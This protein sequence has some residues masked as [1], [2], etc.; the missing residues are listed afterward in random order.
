MTRYREAPVELFSPVES[1][2]TVAVPSLLPCISLSPSTRSHPPHRHSFPVP[3]ASRPGWMGNS[4]RYI[5]LAREKPIRRHHRLPSPMRNPSARNQSFA[6]SYAY[7]TGQ[8]R[9]LSPRSR[10]QTGLPFPRGPPSKGYSN[11]TSNNGWLLVPHGGSR[12]PRKRTYRVSHATKFHPCH[13]ELSLNLHGFRCA[14]ARL[15]T[16]PSRRIG[17]Q[18]SRRRA[19]TPHTERGRKICHAPATPGSNVFIRH[20]TWRGDR[21]LNYGASSGRR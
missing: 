10:F 1:G 4:K 11:A 8:L 15:L 13:R 12:D 17:P 14:L 6:N 2:V 7:E 21:S 3:V 5:F 16:F 19:A 20:F 18:P 9:S